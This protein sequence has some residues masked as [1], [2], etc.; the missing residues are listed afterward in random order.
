MR[1]LTLFLLFAFKSPSY[2]VEIV[3]CGSE[4]EV[5]IRELHAAKKLSNE[6]LAAEAKDGFAINEWLQCQLKD[7]V[8]MDGLSFTLYKSI[9]S[10]GLFVVIHNDFDGT[11]KLYGPFNK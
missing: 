2:A 5:F 8:M 6:S 1:K 9:K 3:K 11:S 10:N 4:D 7:D